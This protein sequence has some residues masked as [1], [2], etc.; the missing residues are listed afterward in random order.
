MCDSAYATFLKWQ[1]CRNEPQIKCCQR[2]KMGW[3]WQGRGVV[4]KESLC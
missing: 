1:N 2:F 3:K 4:P